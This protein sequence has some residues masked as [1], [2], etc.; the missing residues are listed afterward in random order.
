M[1]RL[2]KYKPIQ[3]FIIAFLWTWVAGFSA[4]YLSYNNGMERIQPALI[5][6]GMCG[7]FIAA[8]IMVYSSNEKILIQ[9][10]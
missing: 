10:F 6:L 5:F 8:M 4:A 1:Q 9:D 3:F 2:Y 7:P